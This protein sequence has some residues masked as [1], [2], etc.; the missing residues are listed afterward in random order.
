MPVFL[1]FYEVKESKSDPRVL[2]QLT[3]ALMG[4]M[5]HCDI[6]FVKD[7]ISE[8]FTLNVLCPNGHPIMGQ[9]RYIFDPYTEEEKKKV[10]ESKYIPLWYR[11]MIPY[12]MEVEVRLQCNRAVSEKRYQLSVAELIGCVLP[13]RFQRFYDWIWRNSFQKSYVA[14]NSTTIIPI[15][16]SG[17]CAIMLRD[18]CAMKDIP[19]K[20]SCS[21]L[22]YY[23][24]VGKKVEKV[25]KPF[26]NYVQ[27]K[28][29]D[30][31]NIKRSY[32]TTMMDVEPD[33]YV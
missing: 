9:K 19:T 10:E 12:E 18:G 21:D 27:W 13:V 31:A 17:L 24:I 6:V 25:K 2:W 22:L 32:S 14:T 5:A 30:K 1:V 7:L 26:G 11:L 16:C 29:R 3:H 4:P 8:C 20:G 33:D 28:T 15:H 23:L